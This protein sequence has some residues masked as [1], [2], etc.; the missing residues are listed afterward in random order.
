[1]SIQDKDQSKE[2]D[3]QINPVFQ[4]LTRPPM[5]MGITLD[6]LMFSVLITLCCFMSTAKIS[7]AFIYIPFHIFGWLGCKWDI[8]FFHVLLIRKECPLIKNHKLWGC[9]S[10]EAI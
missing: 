1:M 10:Y 5:F 4:A 8:H 3:L 9:N 6:Y 7:Y 2:Q